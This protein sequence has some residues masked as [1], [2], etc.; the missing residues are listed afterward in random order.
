MENRR[1]KD[2]YNIIAI[3]YFDMSRKIDYRT[4][5]NLYM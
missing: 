1:A 4:L 2:I 3:L 5:Y